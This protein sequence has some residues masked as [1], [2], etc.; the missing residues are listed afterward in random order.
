MRSMVTGTLLLLLAC[1]GGPR[2]LE[3]QPGTVTLNGAPREARSVG[4]GT[5]PF[6]PDCCEGGRRSG[7]A[8]CV[9]DQWTCGGSPFCTCAGKPQ[10]F[11]CAEY[12]GS[13]AFVA[14][15]CV[16]GQWVCSR[17][18]MPTSMCRADTCWGEPGECC[19]APSCVDGGWVC[20][21]RPTT[22]C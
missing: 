20:G 15:D 17:P 3:L 12:C 1:S 13:D 21:F 19:G 16:N 18:T 8:R 5:L 11:L 6:G 2:S 9:A 10:E 22:G 7:E 4:C 14:P